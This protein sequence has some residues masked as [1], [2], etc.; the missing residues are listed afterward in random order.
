MSGPLLKLG[1]AVVLVAILGAI[2]VVVARS[3]RRRAQ[4]VHC[5]TNLRELGRLG[6]KEIFG[7]GLDE[8]QTG[9]RIW[10]EVR[11][12][13]CRE[14]K[15]RKKN[16]LIGARDVRILAEVGSLGP[17]LSLPEAI[18]RARERG[19]DLVETTPQGD[20]RVCRMADTRG[21]EAPTDCRRTSCTL[22]THW[23]E[24]NRT[25]IA[26]FVCPVYGKTAVDPEDPLA[27][28]Y[29]GPKA[30]PETGEK[31]FLIGADRPGNHPGSG[32]FVLFAD[33]SV[34]EQGS[35]AWP[36]AADSDLW[37]QAQAGLSD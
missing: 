28:D 17:I 19:L 27:I 34:K 14:D 30:L 23:H 21:E 18:R 3:S 12:R 22:A 37:R 10:H 35:E 13:A 7:P 11:I 9:R 1:A 5:R 20:P 24:W 33:I 26:A 29:L 4:L 25:R 6:A 36:A 8:D 16:E 2:L 15:F 31:R 32:G